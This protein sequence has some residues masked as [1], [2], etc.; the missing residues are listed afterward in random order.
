MAP[1]TYGRHTHQVTPGLLRRVHGGGLRGAVAGYDFATGRVAAFE[2]LESS[3][4]ALDSLG[5]AS[6]LVALNSPGTAS[7]GKPNLPGGRSMAAASSQRFDQGVADAALGAG[8]S[9]SFGIVVVGRLNGGAGTHGVFGDLHQGLEV[10]VRASDGLYNSYTKTTTVEINLAAG[11]VFP[12]GVVAASIVSHD[13]SDGKTRMWYDDTLAATGGALTADDFTAGLRLMCGG[14]ES[15]SRLLDQDVFRVW[16]YRGRALDQA[17]A[18][19]FYN[20]GDFTA[21]A[22]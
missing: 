13:R 7:S 14:N 10:R 11:A 9:E 21:F 16:V 6:A 19:A 4:D 18:D 2:F 15:G 17:F 3:G 1:V 20:G 8:P 22:P 5:S 12:T